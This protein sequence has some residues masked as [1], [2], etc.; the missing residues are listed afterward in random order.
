MK[1][2]REKEKIL[3]TRIFSFSHNVCYPSKK[4][5]RFPVT[6][7]LSSANAFNLDL[8]KNLSFGKELTLDHMNKYLRTFAADSLKLVKKKKDLVK[9]YEIT[10]LV[11][12]FE[13]IETTTE[14]GQN[15]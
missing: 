9:L 8:S 4:N 1:M 12:V 10:V 6:F 15:T 11:F 3:V 7:I 14:K 5:F 13:R 2:L